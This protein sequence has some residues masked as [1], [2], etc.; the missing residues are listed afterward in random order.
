MRKINGTSNRIGV[1]IDDISDPGGTVVILNNK[2]KLIP[3]QSGSQSEHTVDSNG[4]NT[5]AY[6]GNIPLITLGDVDIS[7]DK[8]KQS[9]GW[10]NVHSNLLKYS[11]PVFRSLI[12]E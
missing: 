9:C 12:V 10:D 2:Y 6:S 4:D 8:L 5:S 3:D 11:A 7:I 1:C